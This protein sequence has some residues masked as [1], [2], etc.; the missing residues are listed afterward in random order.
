MTIKPWRVAAAM[1]LVAF[2]VVPFGIRGVSAAAVAGPCVGNGLYDQTAKRG[3]IP[4]RDSAGHE[5]PVVTIHGITGSD[6]DFDN[7]IDKS[8]IEANPK[9]P[10]SL[11]DAFAGP[12]A[13]GQTIPPGL[14]GVHVYSFSYTPDSLRWVDNPRVGPKFAAAIDCL[15]A[16]YGVP[17]SVVAHSMGGLVT[18]WVANTKDASGMPRSAKLGKVVTLGTPY[19]GSYVAL[20]ALGAE[21]A[22]SKYP[23]LGRVISLIS[24]LCGDLGTNSGK[25]NCGSVPLL[26]AL[27]SEAGKALQMGSRKLASLHRWPPGMDVAAI[28][29]SIKV[30]FQLLGSPLNTSVDLGDI[31]GGTTAS[32]TADP[33][34]A[35]VFECRYDSASGS[36]A[37][38]LKM[39]LKLAS[40]QER[41]AQLQNLFL[42]SPCY[43]SYLMRNV[44]L[45]NEVLGQL[46]DWLTAHRSIDIGK[47]IGC[48]EGCKITGQ[49][50]FQHPTWGA[51]TLV[52]TKSG[53]DWPDARVRMVVIDQ[54]RQIRWSRE[55]TTSYESLAPAKL[56]TDRTGH[57]F[58]D[59]N[60]GRLNGV[61][62]LEPSTDGFRDFNT[63]PPADSYRGR[64]YYAEATDVDGDGTVEILQ[65]ETCDDC[66]TSSDT[67]TLYRWSGDDYVLLRIAPAPP[68]SPARCT[69]ESLAGALARINRDRGDAGSTEAQGLYKHACTEGWAEVT[70]YQLGYGNIGNSGGFLHVVNGEWQWA[71]SGDPDEVPPY[72]VPSGVRDQLGAEIDST[73]TIDYVTF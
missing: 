52:T 38:K 65:S 60:P 67:R 46:N 35:R 48:V 10:R 9:P 20:M 14:P 19:Q 42:G 49:I 16:E 69:P 55:W 2:T 53:G 7:T 70:T 27:N 39:V 32:T 63:L 31:L 43:H 47:L 24:Y 41:H 15:Y 5:F 11:L 30:P 36:A 8:Y 57:L 29:G 13:A 26:S 34:P 44:E 58:I 33:G 17:V 62:V 28:A 37:T 3:R 22:A 59:Y 71:E 12:S 73:T 1:S 64:F 23:N 61:I 18:R 51:S 6:Q 25:G 4:E 50:K 56:A 68:G 45:T 66:A 21:Q 72:P 40:P 54:Q